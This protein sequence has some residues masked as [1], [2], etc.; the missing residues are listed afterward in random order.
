MKYKSKKYIKK[1]YKSNKNTIKYR[2]SAKRTKII[3]RKSKKMKGGALALGAISKLPGAVSKIADATKEK[4]PGVIESE[5]IKAKGKA[6]DVVPSLKALP[7]PMGA[8][9]K[10]ASSASDSLK[11]MVPTS[12]EVSKA[13]LPK[14]PTSKKDVAMSALSMVAKPVIVPWKFTKAILSSMRNVATATLLL[15]TLSMNQILPPELCKYY[16]KNDRICSQTVSEYLFKG[17]KADFE[18][19]DLPKIQPT[20]DCIEFNPNTNKYEQCK[21]DK[22]K[23]GSG[24]ELIIRCK[25]KIHHGFHKNDRVMVYIEVPSGEDPIVANKIGDNTYIGKI[26]SIGGNRDQDFEIQL[27]NSEEDPIK[28]EYN[29]ADP[30]IMKYNKNFQT[31][32]SEFEKYFKDMYEKDIKW[33][34]K[35][36]KRL[37]KAM[38]IFLIG[39][40]YFLLGILA[41]PTLIGLAAALEISIVAVGTV[42]L[43]LAIGVGTPVLLLALCY[44]IYI[45]I[46]EMSPSRKAIYLA[47]MK[48]LIDD[49][50][51]KSE[52]KNL[53]ILK[54]LVKINHNLRLYACPKDKLE[55][56][57][58]MIR[59]IRLLE[60]IQDIVNQF[61]EGENQDHDETQERCDT[62]YDTLSERQ[63]TLTK[64]KLKPDIEYVRTKNHLFNYFRPFYIEP[65]EKPPCKKINRLDPLRILD[66][67]TKTIGGDKDNIAHIVINVF[68]GISSSDGDI[69]DNTKEI[70]KNIQCR[71]GLIDIIKNRIKVIKESKNRDEDD[72]EDEAK[73]TEKK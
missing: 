10:I 21:P 61:L 27:E 73:K 72:A 33:S 38:N 36:N 7:T 2:K 66:T 25:S 34:K 56:I 14:T 20:K 35:S 26:L 24:K 70:L 41:L 40:L 55:S 49:D 53:Y 32:L 69:Y 6:M 29:E 18:K 5:L 62:E 37:N 71:T 42:Q 11:K 23:G 64:F 48:R 8:L 51:V 43:G 31:F 4:G 52:K 12:T 58:G 50:K 17:S 60:K 16:L 1:K 3:N 44:E 47:T 28:V 68:Q 22:M 67:F 46:A 45:K 19:R 30:N 9:S 54:Q 57:F 59:D 13:M 65:E 15:P 63:P 39:S